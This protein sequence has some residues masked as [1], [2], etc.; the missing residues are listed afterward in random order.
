[1]SWSESSLGKEYMRTDAPVAAA[2]TDKPT[3]SAKINWR[4]PAIDGLRA[5]AM[6]M[7]FTFHV[8]E[9]GGSPSRVVSL[10]GLPMDLYA[11]VHKFELGVDLFMV[12]SGF[13]LFLPLCKSDRALWD[14]DWR[15]YARRRIRRIVPP[16]YAA[17][18]YTVFLPVVLVA[19][20]RVLH[21]EANWQ[22]FPPLYQVITHALFVHTLTKGTWGEI[23]G[24]F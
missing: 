16:Y 17:I 4:I 9:F 18:A 1:M 13:C 23:N 10:A 12:L 21:L 6:L 8:W 3:S 24:S 20:F 14:W 11:L 2:A 22:P 19:L 5:L 7:V 15:N